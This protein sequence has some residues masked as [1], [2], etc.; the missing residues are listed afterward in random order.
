[1]PRSWSKDC[2]IPAISTSIIVNRATKGSAARRNGAAFSAT[3][4]FQ[5]GKT[6]RACAE[7][8]WQDIVRQPY[9]HNTAFNRLIVFVMTHCET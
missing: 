5:R 4:Q 6:R 9:S 7:R 1:L 8:G 3:V 2:T